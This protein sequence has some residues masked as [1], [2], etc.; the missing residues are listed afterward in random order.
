MTEK[1][2]MLNGE[3]YD[4]ADKELR[5]AR[6]KARR[7]CRQFNNSTETEKKLRTKLLKELFETENSS[8]WIEP[9]FQCDYGFNIQFGEKVFLNFNC[10]ILDTVEVSI[11]NNVMFGPGV[12]LYTAQHPI[13]PKE[14]AS[15]LEKAAPISIAN[16]VW[17]GGGSII[18]PGVSIG[19]GSVIGAGSVVSKDIPAGVVAVGNPCKV[20]RKITEKD[21]I[22]PEKE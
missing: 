4:P 20:L 3:I 9:P 10:V 17:V 19:E 14:R 1:D 16:D 15:W 13:H 6:E 18:C 12:Q 22:F 5:R 8:I 2:K 21:H 7:L 11:G